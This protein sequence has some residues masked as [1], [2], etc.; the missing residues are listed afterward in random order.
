MAWDVTTFDFTFS[1]EAVFLGKF[2]GYEPS[3]RTIPELVIGYCYVRFHVSDSLM[4]K[5]VD[6]Q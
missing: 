1:T 6:N 2:E 3:V 4:K 5:T